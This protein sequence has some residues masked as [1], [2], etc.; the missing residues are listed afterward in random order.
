LCADGEN[1][2]DDIVGATPGGVDC[3]T[4][5]EITSILLSDLTINF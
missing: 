1:K 3:K 5:L 2:S 4:A